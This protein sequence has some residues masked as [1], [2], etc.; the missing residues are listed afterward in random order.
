M[1]DPNYA[2]TGD[3]SQ[4]TLRLTLP[5]DG[6]QVRRALTPDEALGRLVTWVDRYQGAITEKINP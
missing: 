2:G 5:G 4:V 3:V 6:I 1:W